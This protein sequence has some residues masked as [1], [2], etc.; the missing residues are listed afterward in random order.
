MRQN[1]MRACQAN[2]VSVEWLSEESFVEATCTN[3]RPKIYA[4]SWWAYKQYQQ[5]KF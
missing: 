3:I 2:N 1:F 4:Q 5:E